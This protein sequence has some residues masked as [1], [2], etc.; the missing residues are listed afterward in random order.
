MSSES[1]RGNAC[2]MA[3]NSAPG[4]MDRGSD[5]SRRRPRTTDTHSK[6]Q[7]RS[8]WITV[9]IVADPHR[10]DVHVHIWKPQPR[11]GRAR[12]SISRSCSNSRLSAAF[13]DPFRSK[14]PLQSLALNF[15]LCLNRGSER[16]TCASGGETHPNWSFTGSRARGEP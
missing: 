5:S 10:M 8:F 4:G 12:D 16:I 1:F 6:A 11:L 7:R 14:T 3:R 9:D 2:M 13:L 15:G